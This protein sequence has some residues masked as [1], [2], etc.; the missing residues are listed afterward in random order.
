MEGYYAAVGGGIHCIDYSGIIIGNTISGNGGFIGYCDGGIN[1]YINSSPIIDSCIIADNDNDGVYCGYGSNPEIHYNDIIDNIGYGVRNT[2]SSVTVNTDNNWW[3]DATGP[4]HPDSNP[5]GLG[6][7]VSDSVDSIPWLTAPGIKEQP[8]IK[9][10]ERDDNLGATIFSDPLLLPEGRKCKVFDIT[11][12]VVAP[13][14]MK[15][16]IYF[17]EID[18]QI[19]QKVVK[20]R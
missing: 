15:P 19:I 8:I 3:G 9:P 17:V 2:S 20:A 14:K 12:R 11:G 16:G 6:D 1:C 10:I 18:G 13:D 7:S 5:G 4:Y